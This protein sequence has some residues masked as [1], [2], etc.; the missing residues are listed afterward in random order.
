MFETQSGQ[1]CIAS[2]FILAART[3]PNI[4][5]AYLAKFNLKQYSGIYLAFIQVSAECDINFVLCYVCYE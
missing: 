5:S 4:L 1:Y 2:K 3:V